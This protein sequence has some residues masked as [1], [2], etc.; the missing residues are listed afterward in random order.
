[1]YIYSHIFTFK[2]LLKMKF[3]LIVCVLF[4]LFKIKQINSD[5][6]LEDWANIYSLKYIENHWEIFKLINNKTY[7]NTTEEDQR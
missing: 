6:V 5:N 3:D 2:F 7:S 1:V 4:C